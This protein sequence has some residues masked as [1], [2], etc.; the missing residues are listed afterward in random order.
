MPSRDVARERGL[1][2]ILPDYRARTSWM[3]PKAEADLAQIIKRLKQQFR[4]RHVIV[5]GASMG[6]ASCLTFAALHPELVDGVAS[7]NGTANHVEYENFQ[8][9][10]R[11]SFGG[12]K[13]EIPDEYRKRK[14]ELWPERFTMPS[15]F[16]VGG[17]DKAC[18]P[19]ASCVSRR[20]CRP[21]GRQTLLIHR[22]QGGHSTNYAD[23]TEIVRFVVD[24]ARE[25][26]AP[27]N[28]D[29]R[30]RGRFGR[31][32]RYWRESRHAGSSRDGC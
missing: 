8:D 17:Q 22:E 9:A 11:E 24:Q 7:M 12:T 32:G 15:A 5:S 19:T 25:A 14:A 29:R 27:K 10:I 13:A 16:A 4:V 26:G 30:Q 31:S 23:A 28:A 18:R 3:G 21:M 2:L 1:L 6:G 20:S